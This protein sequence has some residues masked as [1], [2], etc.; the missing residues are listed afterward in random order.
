[1]KLLHIIIK[2]RFNKVARYKDEV[3]Y[4]CSICG[5]VDFNKPIENRCEKVQK[6]NSVLKHRGIDDN[7]IFK[8]KNGVL[9]HNRLSIMDIKKGKQPMKAY[10]NGYCYTIVYNGEI[11]NCEELKKEL[12]SEEIEFKTTCDTEVVLY[13]YMVFGEKCVEKLNGIFAFAIFDEQKEKVFL[14]RDRF[15]IKPFFFAFDDS[16]FAFASEIKAL[17]SLSGIKPIIDKKGLWQLLFLSP[18]TLEGQTVFKNIFEIKPGYCGS[19]SKKGLSLY[20]YFSLKPEKLDVTKDEAAKEVKRLLLDTVKRQIKSDV[21]LC[22]FLSGGLDSSALSALVAREYVAQGKV[23]STYS[24]EYEGNKKNFKKSLFQPQGD[25][26]Y[27]VYLADYLKTDHTVLTASSEIVAKYLENATKFRDFPGQADIDSSLLYFCEQVKK[28]HSVA[29]SGECSDEIFGG[30]PWF[31]RQEMLN[32]EFFPFVHKPFARANLFDKKIVM[33]NEGY[34]YLS[35]IYKRDLDEVECL[36]DDSEQDIT[37]RKASHLSIKYFMTNL[38]ERKDRMSMASSLEVRVPFADHRLAQFVYN[39]PWK[40]KFEG[41]VEKALLRNAVKEY[42]PEK[43]LW[44]KKSPYPKTHNPK[45]EKIVTKMLEKRLK[46][47]SRIAEI[48]DFCVY[49][50]LKQKENITWFGQLMAKPQ[51]LAW[52][53]QLDVFLSEYDCIIE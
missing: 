18:I 48:L 20:K 36:P 7:G 33:A 23:L 35:K 16:V 12:E 9:A 38:L 19:F 25:D 28:E 22:T 47:D 34:E 39:V 51:L 10:K 15:G 13:S 30:Y 41:E 8:F 40:I 1:M 29:I 2:Q 45:Y 53:I 17:L 37:A 26:E 11:Y 3:N 4:M 42:L 43:I 5:L 52:L 49:K 21:P 6:M 44:R 27:A 32:S 46:N 50:S 31:Y 24:F 14:A